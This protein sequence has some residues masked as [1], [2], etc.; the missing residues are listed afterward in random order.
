M[1]CQTPNL[2]DPRFVCQKQGEDRYQKRHDIGFSQNVREPQ[3]PYACL[4]FHVADVFKPFWER[5]FEVLKIV[6]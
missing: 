6:R 3:G 1:S 5:V 2:G 4:K